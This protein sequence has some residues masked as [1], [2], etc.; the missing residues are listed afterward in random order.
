M[1]GC[2]TIDV[3][4]SEKDVIQELE[5][6]GAQYALTNRYRHPSNQ[7]LTE[8]R[9]VG[10]FVF[11]LEKVVAMLSHALAFVEEVGKKKGSIL[12]VSTRRETTDLIQK[13]AENLSQPYMINR[14]IGGVISNFK[15]VRSRVDRMEKLAKENDEGAWTQYT[16]KERVLLTRELSKLKNKFSGIASMTEL[17]AAVVVFD[18]KREAIAVKEALRSH[19]PIVG[20]SN[21]NADIQLVQYPVSLNIYSRNVTAYVLT[22]IEEAYRKGEKAT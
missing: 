4:Q 18:V 10:Q 22:R 14:W 21:V 19:I 15:N 9:A 3:M 17:P 7:S 8:Q 2:D 12:F 11:D 13:T 20:I 6:L 16:K 5:N 1:V